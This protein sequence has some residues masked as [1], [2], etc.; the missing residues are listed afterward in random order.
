VFARGAPFYTIQKAEVF[1]YETWD[2]QQGDVPFAG[3][4]DVLVAAAGGGVGCG[5][6]TGGD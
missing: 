2:I 3:G 4:G 5:C 6:A 1:H